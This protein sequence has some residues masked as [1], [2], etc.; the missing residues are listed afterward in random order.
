M[1]LEV[2]RNF[3]VSRP[4][5]QSTGQ[6]VVSVFSFSGMLANNRDGIP[7]IVSGHRS[8]SADNQDLRLFFFA[9]MLFFWLAGS[10]SGCSIVGS[11]SLD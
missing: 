9:A 8:G 10:R 6:V 5:L 2:W 4:Y 1:L 3:G 11:G 7:A